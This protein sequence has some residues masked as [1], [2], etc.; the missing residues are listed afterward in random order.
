M[1]SRA[2][3]SDMSGVWSKGE[4]WRMTS[5][6]MKQASMKMNRESIRVEFI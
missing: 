6:P 5:K 3:V 2:L 4:T 1:A